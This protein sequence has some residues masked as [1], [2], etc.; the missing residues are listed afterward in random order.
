MSSTIAD[1]LYELLGV[2]EGATDEEIRRNYK[3]LA[4]ELHPDRFVGDPAAQGDASDRFQKVS[5]AYNVLKD[6]T[7]RSEYDFEKK[8]ARQGNL[9]DNIEVVDKPVEETGYKRE[10][11]DR[12]YKMGLQLQAEGD[13]SKAVEVLKEAIGICP[14]VAQYHALLAALYDRRGWHSYAKA[15]IEAALRLDPDDLLSQ[16]LQKRLLGEIAKR[17]VEEAEF[18]AARATKGKKKGKKSKK[19]RAEPAKAKPLKGTQAFKRKPKSWLALLID[20]ILH[21]NGE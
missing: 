21:R 8:L 15:E 18:E 2:S 10:V 9:A 4:K 20:K 13:L 19:G 11:A 12:K 17:E 16:K 5:H 6:P 14:N 7:Q 1:D 3:R